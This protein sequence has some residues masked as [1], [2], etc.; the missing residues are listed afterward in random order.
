MTKKDLYDP[1]FEHDSC[2]VGFVAHVNGEQSHDIVSK[3]ITILKN[4]VHRG[5]LGGDRKTGDGAGMLTQIPHEFFLSECAKAGFAL[6]ERGGYGVAMIFL[7]QDL[8]RRKEAKSLVETTVAGEGGSV[9]GWRDVPVRPECLGDMAAA[10][11]PFVSQAFFTYEGLSGEAL[12]R[13]LYVSRKSMERQAL[14]AGMSLDD[15]YVPSLSCATIN[16]K[17]MF[18]APQFDSFYPDLLD[19][20]FTS[21]IALVHQRYS[22]NTFPS[23]CLSQPF[24]YCAHNGEINTLRG[25]INKMKA[26]ESTLSSPLF[27]ADIAKLLPIIAEGG[28]D[29]AMFDNVFEL[30]VLGGRSPEH[31]MMMMIPEAFGVRYHISEDKRAFYE[32]HASIMEPWDGPAAFSFTNGTVVGAAL[33]RNGL[34]PARY[35]VT[36]SGLVVLASEIGVLDI[37]AGDVLEKGRLAPG[38]MILVDTARHRVYLEYG[39]LIPVIE[40]LD[41][42]GWRLKVWTTR[43]GREV[44]GSPFAKNKL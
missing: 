30:L 15:F 25:N 31:S 18:V 10:S 6:P 23:W 1:F 33:D 9:I 11:M 41:Q 17:G 34:R 28:S 24:R 12:E 8:S 2:G 4:L 44:G 32:Y 21:A 20:K 22:T 19:E 39:S 38:K 37:P 43:E 14:S 36:R 42:R 7:P 29:S 35:V 16:Y 3:G 13:K 5:A 27:G 40:Q 26:R